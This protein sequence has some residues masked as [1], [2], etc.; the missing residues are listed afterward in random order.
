MQYLTQAGRKLI[1]EFK[2]PSIRGT[3]AG[4]QSTAGPRI[5]GSS[6]KS[7]IGG[8]G[9]MT[10]AGMAPS[11]HTR[12]R[13]PGRANVT[14]G[15]R[16]KEPTVPM[17][18]GESPKVPYADQNKALGI[19]S[20][21]VGGL[22][23]DYIQRGKSTLP[24]TL[25][26]KDLESPSIIRKTSDLDKEQ[27]M[28]DQGANPFAPGRAFGLG[29]AD[30]LQTTAQAGATYRRQIDRSINMDKYEVARKSGTT[31]HKPIMDP[32]ARRVPGNISNTRA[33]FQPAQ[34]TPAGHRDANTPS[35][36]ALKPLERGRWRTL[37]DGGREWYSPEKYRR[38]LQAYT[39]LKRGL[40][41]DA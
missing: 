26:R 1:N 33:G 16:T 2:A 15:N 37:K 41:S 7:D 30:P 24:L 31:L 17:D 3:L 39:G 21:R 27:R 9:S 35:V 38:E 5:G 20:Q 12:S 34:E 25:H 11:P 28:T 4:A 32:Q 6:G 13:I 8:A 40:R 29:P 36:K 19:A 23:R 18:G 10:R 14:V 22:N